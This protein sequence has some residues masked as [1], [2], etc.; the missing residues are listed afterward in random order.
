MVTGGLGMRLRD[1]QR[2]Y[3]LFQK[4]IHQQTHLHYGIVCLQKKAKLHVASLH[5]DM[6][7]ILNACE[8]FGRTGIT[9]QVCYEH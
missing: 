9:R 1:P 4:K 2:S 8:V 5:F 3:H 7:I 6:I